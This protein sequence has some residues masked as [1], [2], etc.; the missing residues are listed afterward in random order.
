MGWIKDK[1]ALVKF[2]F[3][4]LS[5]IIIV[6]VIVFATGVFAAT[7]TADVTIKPVWTYCGASE[8]FTV[9]VKSIS[10]D[11]I[12]EVR[13]YNTYNNAWSD[14]ACASWR[15]GWFLISS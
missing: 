6:G 5:L 9:N 15:L 11:P 14:F 1:K 13:I 8:T 2:S 12:N 7:H 4:I 10:G 3:L